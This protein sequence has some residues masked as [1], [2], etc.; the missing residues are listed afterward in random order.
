MWGSGLFVFTLF[1]LYTI[2]IFKSDYKRYSLQTWYRIFMITSLCTATLLS[3]L[4]AAFIHYVSDFYQL[5]IMAILVAAASVSTTSL[6]SDFRIAIAYIS[7]L[8]P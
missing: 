8:F 7:I 4:G 2:Y 5:F 1:R 3:L 6:S